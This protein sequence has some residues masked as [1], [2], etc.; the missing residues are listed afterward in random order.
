MFAPGRYSSGTLNGLL[1]RY[2]GPAM[3][4]ANLR[5]LGMRAVDF[6]CP[7][8]RR[9]SV[10]VWP[11]WSQHRASRIGGESRGATPCFPRASPS[12]NATLPAKGSLSK[13]LIFSY[14]LVE[15]DGI[16]PTT[17]SMPLKRSPN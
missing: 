7:C 12:V 2:T 17:S 11:D 3:D 16:E 1:P 10:D 15:P 8:G 5:S 13:P 4:L 9:E 6:S 14:F